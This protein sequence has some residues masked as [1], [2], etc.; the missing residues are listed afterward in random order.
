[1]FL[2]VAALAG[3]MMAVQGTINSVLGKK[4]GLAETTFIVHAT[5]AI[6]LVFILFFK[7]N[8]I[9]LK[10]FKEIPWYLYLGGGMGVIITYGVVT[11]IPK[12]GVAVTTTAIITAQ[13]LTASVIDHLGVLGLEPVS[14]NW[15]KLIG[16]L[17][18]AVGVRLLLH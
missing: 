13:I 6:I 10:V 7:N 9:N 4:I 18:M 8:H 12:L 1:M 11:S 17:L 5:A 14:F 2:G 16:I 15:V 3:L